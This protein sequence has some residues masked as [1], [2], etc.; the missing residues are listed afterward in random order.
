MCR[1]AGYAFDGISCTGKL[2]TVATRMLV[3]PF[4]TT[5][6]CYSQRQGLVFLSLVSL[7]NPL[8]TSYFTCS[9]LRRHPRST[10]YS[11]LGVRVTWMQL[12]RLAPLWGIGCETY[13]LTLAVRRCICHPRSTGVVVAWHMRNFLSWWC[14]ST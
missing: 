7:F 8:T 12:T 5:S 4:P 6:E 9:E 13:H 10:G 2:K 1:S 11:L 14:F 3:S